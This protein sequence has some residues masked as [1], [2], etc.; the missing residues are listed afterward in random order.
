MRCRAFGTVLLVSSVITGCSTP[1]DI[2]PQTKLATKNVLSQSKSLDSLSSNYQ[3]HWPKMNW[4]KK[5]DDKQL[6]GLITKA[7]KH[8]PSID[9]ADARLAQAQSYIMQANSAFE[10]TVNASTYYRRARLSKSEDYSFQGNKYSTLRGLGLNFSYSFDLWGGKKAQWQAAVNA[11][12]AMEVEHQAAKLN[13]VSEI[14]KQ[15]IQLSNAYA[16]LDLANKDLNRAERIVDITQKLL[17]HGLTS[18]DKL[19][20]AQSGE[21]SAKR[22]EKERQLVVSKLKNALAVLSGCGVDSAS[23]IKRPTLLQSK[24]VSLP[25]NIAANLLSHRPDITSALWRVKSADK[26]IKV[27][28]TQFYPNFNLSAMAGFKSVLGDAVFGGVS[29][30]WNVTPAFSLPIF[31]GAL[32]A[33]LSEK[34]AEYDQAVA[35]YNQTLIEALGE[36][37]NSI[38]TLRSIKTQLID[39]ELSVKLARK[40]YHITEKRY[41]AGMGSQLEVLMSEQRLLNAEAAFVNLE[42]DQKLEKVSLIHSIGGGFEKMINHKD[43]DNSKTK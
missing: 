30:S 39:A 19:Y 12:K 16:L 4:W 37:A 27:A 17:S 23:E 10:P 34:T 43:I 6:S 7:L 36:V 1:N 35:Q 14:V 21:S 18:E 2:Y 13:L 40:S 33:N 20:S 8:S 42:N 15:Y 24:D 9:L 38:D 28:K 32:K 11:E 31:T 22:I 41:E 26:S 5:Y 29:R 25:N 3:A